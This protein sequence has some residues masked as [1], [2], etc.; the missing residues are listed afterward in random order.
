MVFIENWRWF[1]FEV[2]VICEVLVFEVGYI[3]SFDGEVLGFVVIGF[4]GGC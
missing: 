4:G 1:L 2:F 3:V